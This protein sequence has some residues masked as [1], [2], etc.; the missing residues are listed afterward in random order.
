MAPTKRRIAAMLSF[1]VSSCKLVTKDS[2]IPCGEHKL[3]DFKTPLLK[4]CK[5][6]YVSTRIWGMLHIFFKSFL[7]FAG[8]EIA[9]FVLATLSRTVGDSFKNWSVADGWFESIIC[10]S[11]PKNHKM[12][13]A[14]T[15]TPSRFMVSTLIES[16]SFAHQT[17][18]L[19]RILMLFA[20][21]KHGR[22]IAQ[23]F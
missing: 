14:R 4:E 22:S 11:W 21:T 3:R 13:I 19:D 12:H 9:Q 18:M 16:D 7:S 17:P 15:H 8:L 6:A 5:F 10:N 20:T 2:S 23:R 1:F